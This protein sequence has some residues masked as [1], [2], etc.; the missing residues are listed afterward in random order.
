MNVYPF[1]LNR[2]QR[3]RIESSLQSNKK[4]GLILSAILTPIF[5]SIVE[6]LNAVFLGAIETE[7]VPID[8]SFFWN[9]CL[10]W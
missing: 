5:S 2:A 6:A 9:D 7:R 1:R 3:D 8:G 10:E 4:S